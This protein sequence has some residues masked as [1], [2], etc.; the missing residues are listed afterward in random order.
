MPLEDLKQAP[1]TEPV[2]ESKKR[3]LNEMTEA[4]KNPEQVKKI[5]VKPG[6]KR[7]FGTFKM[8][9]KAAQP[10]KKQDPAIL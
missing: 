4:P 10:D 2:V 5:A 6:Q 1:P 3:P 7:S 9:K 8:M